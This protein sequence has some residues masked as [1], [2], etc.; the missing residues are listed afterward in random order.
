[1]VKFIKGFYLF[2]KEKEKLFMK[3]VVLFCTVFGMLLSTIFISAETTTAFKTEKIKYPKGIRGITSVTE[4]F[5]TG[6]QV[7]HIIL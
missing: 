3:K 4:V 5:G 6:Q 1:M 7:T 2:N